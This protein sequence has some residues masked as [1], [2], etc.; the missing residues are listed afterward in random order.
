M[1]T[2]SHIF[3]S[4]LHLYHLEQSPATAYESKESSLFFLLL[5]IIIFTINIIMIKTP[6]KASDA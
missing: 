1:F 4:K 5:V 3:P 2:E 6:S